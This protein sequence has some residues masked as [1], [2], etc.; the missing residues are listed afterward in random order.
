MVSSPLIL[1]LDCSTGPCSVA[2]WRG[3]RIAA[4]EEE[5]APLRQSKILLPMVERTL[6]HAGIEYAD[7]EL[8]AT[9]TG[10][11]SFTGIRIGL[12]AARGMA[13]AAQ[14]PLMGLTGMEVMAHAQGDCMVALNAGKGEAYVQSFGNGKAQGDIALKKLSTLMSLR[15]PRIL[16]NLDHA[17]FHKGAIFSGIAYPR[18]DRIAALAAELLPGWDKTGRA[19]SPLYIRP[20]DAKP[21]QLPDS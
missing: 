5:N 16:T 20:P 10:P 21:N 15:A 2:V 13:L 17:L 19:T 4:L 14:L 11:G 6:R 12:A 3:G 18:A 9:V 1:A 8:I 7:L